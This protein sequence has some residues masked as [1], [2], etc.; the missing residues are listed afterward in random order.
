[1][2]LKAA[3]NTSNVAYT[4]NW[5]GAVW[6][7]YPANTFS[8]VTGTFTVPTPSAPNG[9]AAVWVGIDGDTC[10][11]AIL[12]TGINMYYQS[13]AISYTSWY[14]WFPDHTYRYSNPITIRAGD[15]IRLTV[16]ASSPTS[17]RT[18]IDNLTTGQSESQSLSH[19]SHPLCLQNAEWIVEDFNLVDGSVTPFCNFGTVTFSSASAYLHNGKVISPSGAVQVNIKQQGK[20]LT[21]V[22]GAIRL[23]SNTY[24]R[25]VP[26]QYV[27]IERM[28]RVKIRIWIKNDCP[29]LEIGSMNQRRMLYE[30]ET[31]LYYLTRSQSF[32]RR[33][34]HH[35][36]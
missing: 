26:T 33:S 7:S 31:Q 29:V 28:Q 32:L 4:P 23:Q 9:D 10:K 15:I 14:E 17:G 35:S 1:M 6:N 36:S 11:T 27:R 22:R 30:E 21:S 2:G 25:L 13:G 16:I 24:H 12:Q 3:T 19:P 18:I 20:V 5:A 8:K 34:W